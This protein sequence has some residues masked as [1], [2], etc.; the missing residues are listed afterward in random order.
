MRPLGDLEHNR[1]RDAVDASGL[2]GMG[3]PVEEKIRMDAE[4]EKGKRE[5]AQLWE[6]ATLILALDMIRG[7]YQSGG[8]RLFWHSPGRVPLVVA[9]HILALLWDLPAAQGHVVPAV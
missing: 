1:V 2:V 7:G 6:E 5:V 3:R 9:M 4:N 8:A